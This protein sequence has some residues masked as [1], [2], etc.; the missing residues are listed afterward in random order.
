MI[1]PNS[2]Y[3]PKAEEIQ[4]TSRA[5]VQVL[6]EHGFNSCL[7]GS[8]AAA[9]YGAENRNPRVWQSSIL[10]TY[11]PMPF[12]PPSTMMKLCLTH[13]LQDV[14]IVVL[15]PLA[16]PVAGEI[17]LEEIKQLI[18]DNAS[19]D[20]YLVP[21]KNPTATYK[22]L[23]YV[24]TPAHPDPESPQHH[25]CKIDL[26]FP[27]MIGIPKRI[28]AEKIH[29]EDYFPD[30]PLIPLGVLLLLKVKAWHE[31]ELDGR[32]HMKEKT[33]QAEVD[34][35]EILDLAVN[36]YM[37][38]IRTVEAWTGWEWVEGMKEPVKKYAARFPDSARLWE[39]IGM[40]L[41]SEWSLPPRAR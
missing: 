3:R 30:I 28:P 14:D 11:N 21:S 36:E 10:Y 1:Y 15:L 18:V 25:A 39:E 4:R 17:T 2:V 9:I 34:V 8:T 40:S 31:Y 6:A 5:I 29:Y 20:F 7:F 22:I 33:K 41:K 38:Q 26:L 27:G 13:W 24:L 35:R 19:S 12:P 16:S 32:T 23:F 37:T